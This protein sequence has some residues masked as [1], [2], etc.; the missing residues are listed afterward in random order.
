MAERSTP[1]RHLCANCR[2]KVEDEGIL[3]PQ[4]HREAARR[5]L[6]VLDAIS[7]RP[8]AGLDDLMEISGL[9]A[10]DI[11]NIAGDGKSRWQPSRD[12]RVPVCVVCSL[13][14]SAGAVCR[15]CTRRLEGR[16]AFA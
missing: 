4:C 10:V 8:D 6:N 14:T 5:K 9:S 12:E 11:V 2:T 15:P 7:R 13:P 1:T 3:C 16:A